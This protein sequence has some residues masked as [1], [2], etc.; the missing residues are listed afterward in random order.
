MIRS[1]TRPAVDFMGV[2]IR[3]TG[4]AWRVGWLER[5][6]IKGRDY[7]T[8]PAGRDVASPTLAI[9]WAIWLHRER[10]AFGG[11]A[12]P[13]DAASELLGAFSAL[14]AGT[15]AATLDDP[16]FLLTGERV[17]AGMTKRELAQ[18]SGVGRRTVQR[19]ENEGTDVKVGTLVRLLRA[20]AD[21]G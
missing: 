14:S 18:V 13:P 11:P 4:S 10:E 3:W 15:L 9:E 19:A 8:I 7:D 20:I 1:S 6:K 2:G 17:G 16:G 21:R 5:R 12:T